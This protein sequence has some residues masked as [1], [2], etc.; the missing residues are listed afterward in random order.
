[1]ALAASLR[2]AA[3]ALRFG[4]PVAAVYHPLAYAWPVHEAWLRRYGPGRGR[5]V[6]VGMNPGPFGMAQTGVPFGDPTFVRDFLHLQGTV[7]PPSGL[8]PRRPVIGLESPRSEVS[9]QRLWGWARDRFG[10]ADAFLRR[11]FVVNW[12]PLAFV[13]AGGR[14]LTPDALPAADRG[15]LQAVCDDALGAVLEELAPSRVLGVGTFAATRA[16]RVAR[17]E[18]G[19]LPHPSPASPRANRGWA[20]LVDAELMALAGC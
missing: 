15:P 2:D 19:C 17:V 20:A 18:V 4:P 5:I 12:C 9:G 6:L 1:V 16:R 7:S 10:T 14:N 13:D 8:H 11:F 3:G